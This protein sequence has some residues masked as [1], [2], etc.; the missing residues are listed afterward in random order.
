MHLLYTMHTALKGTYDAANDSLPVFKLVP[1][2]V[3]LAIFV[4]GDLNDSPFFDIMWTISMYLDTIAMLPQLWMLTKI[5]GEVEALTSHFVAC[6]V[7]SRLCA[8][9]FWFYGYEEI[10]QSTHH[11]NAAGY[12]ILVAHLLQL[13]LSADFMWYYVKSIV[14]QSKMALPSLEV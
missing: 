2:C 13:F 12:L 14:K 8:F 1:A 4:H 10:T 9:S 6:M 7:I 11:F 5:G 3:V